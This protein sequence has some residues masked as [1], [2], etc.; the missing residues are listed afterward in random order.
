MEVVGLMCGCVSSASEG[1]ADHM[2][3]IVE[4]NIYNDEFGINLM[5]K[6]RSDNPS[7]AHKLSG[8]Q[9]RRQAASDVINS[10][11]GS[12]ALRDS[13]RMLCQRV[14]SISAIWS[15]NRA[16]ELHALG[17]ENVLEKITHVT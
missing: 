5:L 7:S 6:V 10:R 1:D 16:V 13:N 9:V 12:L 17:H 11:R 14:K 8:G 2:Y 4:D 3:S 15:D